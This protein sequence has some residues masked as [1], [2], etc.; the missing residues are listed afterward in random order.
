LGVELDES[1]PAATS[2]PQGCATCPPRLRAQRVWLEL[3]L[4]A[5]DLLAWTQRLTLDGPLAVAEPKTLRYR[6]LHV[7][8]RVTRHARRRA[9]RLQRTWPWTPDLLA[10]LT[11]AQALAG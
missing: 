11:R 10:A 3:I 5:C 9:L 8:A 1:T 7:A 4:V 6:L 2:K